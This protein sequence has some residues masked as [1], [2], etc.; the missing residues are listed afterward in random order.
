VDLRKARFHAKPQSRKE[1]DNLF[2]MCAGRYVGQVV[3]LR[4]IGNPPA[5]S[6]RSAELPKATF[7][8]ASTVCFGSSFPVALTS[9]IPLIFGLG[10][11]A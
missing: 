5:G 10:G 2:A 7:E 9:I 3:N 4:R 11:F 6:R 1:L 8:S